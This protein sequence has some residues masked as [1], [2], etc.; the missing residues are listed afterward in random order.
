L[1]TKNLILC[2]VFQ[3]EPKIAM[4]TYKPS[5]T[6]RRYSGDSTHSWMDYQHLTVVLLIELT[7]DPFTH[8][9]YCQIHFTI[10]VLNYNTDRNSYVFKH[11][12]PQGALKVITPKI[13]G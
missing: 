3:R 12:S 1:Q 10:E 13:Q 8:T 6:L 2:Q 9:Q 7:F 5:V 4:N 11:Q